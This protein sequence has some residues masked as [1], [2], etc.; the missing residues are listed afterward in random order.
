[1]D[2]NFLQ[3]KIYSYER[4]SFDEMVS[5]INKL[6]DK[7]Q[8]SEDFRDGDDNEVIFVQNDDLFQDL[9]KLIE[10]KNFTKYEQRINQVI[11]NRKSAKIK[12]VNSP[13]YDSIKE[14]KRISKRI[15]RL[16]VKLKE[17]NED[18]FSKKDLTEAYNYLKQ[19]FA[20][21]V[22]L[23]DYISTSKDDD[24]LFIKRKR[25]REHDLF[26]NT[27]IWFEDIEINPIYKSNPKFHNQYKDLK[28]LYESAITKVS[29][30]ITED[31][32]DLQKQLVIANQ[33]V[34]E[35]EKDRKNLTKTDIEEINRYSRIFVENELNQSEKKEIERKRA[36]AINLRRKRKE[37]L[38]KNFRR[39]PFE[40]FPK[41]NLSI[42]HLVKQLRTDGIQVSLEDER[43]L[44]KIDERFPNSEICLGKDKFNGYV[45]FR[46]KDTDVVIVEKPAYG[47][48]TYLIKGNWE[49]DVLKILQL[50]RGEARINHPTKVKRVIHTTE[51][52]WLARLESKFKYWY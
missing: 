5:H 21:N 23:E 48:A 36:I 52:L 26:L 3:Q 20:E 4:Q 1:M 2:E 43:R 11:K 8:Q 45:V 42:S 10:D 29:K 27:F 38:G 34:S 30:K 19:N 15:K 18:D 31:L 7:L 35:L 6:L 16:N 22:A 51:Y 32:E 50:S 46:F 24:R 41:G 44:H 12:E 47:N 14:R 25:P 33:T 40:I 37:M 49:E 9:M 28:L 13:Y 17:L 39:L